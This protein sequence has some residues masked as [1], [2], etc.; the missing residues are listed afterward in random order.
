MRAKK[1][2]SSGPAIIAL[3]AAVVLVLPTDA[4]AITFEQWATNQGWSA[5]RVMPAQVEIHSLASIDSLAGIANYDWTTTPT[6]ELNLSLNRITSIESGDFTGLIS[7]MDLDL[8]VNLITSVELGDFAGLS[9]LTFLD[10]HTNH[11]T[12][13]ES[14]GFTGLSG[15]TNLNLSSNR[16]TNIESGD[17]TGLSGLTNLIL[18][19]NRITNIESGDFTGLS[20][21]T[22]LNLSSNQITSIESG[23]FSGLSNLTF[24]KLSNNQITSIES[25]AFSGLGNLTNLQLWNNQITTVESGTFTGLRSLKELDLANSQITSVQS[26]AFAGLESLKKLDLAFNQITSIQSG[27]FAE[28]GN[29][30]DLRMISSQITSIESGVFSGLDRLIVLNL[31]DNTSLTNLNFEGADF[32]SLAGFDVTNNT[33]IAR[34][35]LKNAI[36]TQKAL[37]AIVAANSYKDGTGIGYL[38][39]VTE[40]DLSG[41]DFAA[42][43]DLSPLYL[44]DHVTDLWLAD[45][46]HLDAD[47]LD[48]LLD[49]MAAMEDPNV[50][51]V[52]YVTQADYD[53]FNAAGGGKLALWDAEAGHRV[54][55]VPEPTTLALL[56][57]AVVS[58]WLVRR[59]R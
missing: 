30:E 1:P 29:L 55:I 26:G 54:Q 39:G 38:P 23:D 37:A 53:A 49:N 21:L 41:I 20:G 51:G 2:R 25:G 40:L 44:M 50:E 58:L 43:T 13:I 31:S 45:V 3:A 18:S 28:L 4:W 27:I 48:V 5:G 47:E 59:R 11:I 34:A 57:G 6:T 17:F 36:L 14:G 46:L 15:L 52:L 22:N 42:I 16:I 24:L 33:N 19:S 35:S 12:S 7:V 56:A 8:S 32:S 10:L 9:S